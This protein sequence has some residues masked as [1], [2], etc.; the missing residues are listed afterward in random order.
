M[1]VTKTPEVR[2][3]E[4]IEQATK[5]FETRGIGKTSISDIADAVGVAKGL[6]YYYFTSKEQLVTLVIEQFIAGIDDALN[7]IIKNPSLDFYAKL[8]S[9]LDLY[10]HAIPSHPAIFNLTP[11]DPAVFNLIRDKLSEIALAHAG[12][13]LQIGLKDQLIRIEFPEYMLKILIKGL[14]DLYIEGV[15]DPKIH[16]VLVEQVLGLEPGLLLPSMPLLKAAAEPA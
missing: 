15:Q 1:R 4:I 10:Y 6:V 9:I 12:T 8:A 5:L 3:K 13:L 2:K 7:G 14:G 16:V 11:G